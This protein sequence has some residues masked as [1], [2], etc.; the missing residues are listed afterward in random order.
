MFTGICAQGWAQSLPNPPQTSLTLRQWEIGAT[1]GWN[2][3]EAAFY[4][5]FRLIPIQTRPLL[6]YHG[7]LNF[8]YLFSRSASLV[9]GL[10]YTQKG[11]KQIFD[12]RSDV[13]IE[14]I[15]YVAAPLMMRISVLEAL[16]A[17]EAVKPLEVFVLTG[18]F[19]SW[20]ARAEHRPAAADLAG[21]YV[22]P[23]QWSADAKVS[24]GLR[25][26][27]ALGL[28]WNKHRIRVS[29][30]RIRDLS[31]YLRSNP[32]TSQKPFEAQHGL[33]QIAMTYAVNIGQK[34][35]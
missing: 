28:R 29:G 4:D 15:S 22:H 2:I 32:R 35:P 23:F 5:P 13:F 1:G 34:L 26:G 8:A 21:E 19:V 12:T 6:G 27:V 25:V 16:N 7:G 20:V 33:W 30:H 24:F 14:K 10:Q 17:N 18:P 3:A 9:S 11:Y 31:S